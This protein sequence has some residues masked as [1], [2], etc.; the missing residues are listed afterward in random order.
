[1]VA[2]AGTITHGEI[3]QQP[4]I[5]PDTVRRVRAAKMTGITDPVLSG[6]GTSA[7]A[8]MAIESAW[9]GALAIPSTELLLDFPR[10]VRPGGTVISLARSGDSPESV[11]VVQK[12]RQALPTVRHVA[13]TANPKGKLAG[14]EGVE[15]ILLDPRTNDRSLVMTSSISNLVVGGLALARP[16]E[17]EAALPALCEGWDQRFDQ[18]EAKAK[19][20]AQN[21]PARAVVLGSLPL[22]GAAREAC[23]KMLESTAGRVAAISET[24]LGLRHGP[25]SYVQPDSIVLCFLSSDPARRRY[26]VDLAK[27]LRSKK[28]GRLIAVGEGDPE[29]FHDVI[30]TFLWRTGGMPS[31]HSEIGR[32]SCR[33]RVCP[34]V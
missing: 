25:M 22:Y 24:Y 20:I 23:L 10:F 3:K 9:P 7:Y 1:M 6:A 32:A 13:L 8:A 18:H 11:A 5:W 19:A 33:E 21:P 28:L 2:E 27:E 30:T 31:S 29:V 26:E 16:D 34:K 12:I 14:W 17:I 4:E 15:A